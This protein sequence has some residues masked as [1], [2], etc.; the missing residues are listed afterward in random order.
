MFVGK[1]RLLLYN[2]MQVSLSGTPLM[3]DFEPAIML[4]LCIIDIELF[5][6]WSVENW[7]D[8]GKQPKN[9]FLGIIPKLV[10]GRPHITS[11]KFGV[12]CAPPPPPLPCNIVI[13]WEDRPY[14]LL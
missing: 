14:V 6:K 11:Y 3:P 8:K 12:L 4:F 5:L 2:S 7:T 13:N 9:W 1:G 10:R